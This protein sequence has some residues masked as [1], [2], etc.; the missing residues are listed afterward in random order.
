MKG[1]DPDIRIIWLEVIVSYL[2]DIYGDNPS[3]IPGNKSDFF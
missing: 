1:C 2:C 3:L